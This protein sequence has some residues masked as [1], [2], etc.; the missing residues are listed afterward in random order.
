MS[1]PVAVEV[2]EEEKEKEETAE[3]PYE[4]SRM[5]CIYLTF[6]IEETVFYL[7]GNVVHWAFNLIPFEEPMKG[8]LQFWT[9]ICKRSLLFLFLIQWVYLLFELYVQVRYSHVRERF[10][11]F[12][13][14]Y[15][16]IQLFFPIVFVGLV[17]VFNS[18]GFSE[19]VLGAPLKFTG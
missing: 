12:L 4:R 1:L 17:A 7:L 9:T 13:I 14:F 6:S 19:F 10:V 16:V 15:W 18:E 8:W 5:F 3:L 11:T 2:K